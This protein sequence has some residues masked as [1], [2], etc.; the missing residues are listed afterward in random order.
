MPNAATSR[1]GSPGPVEFPALGHADLPL[2]HRWLSAPH[3]RTW[4]RDTLSLEEVER[5][6]GPRIDGTGPIRCFVIEVEGDPIGM[7]QGYRHADLPDGERVGGIGVPAAAGIDYLIGDA[8]RCGRGIGSR[9]I[10][11][12]SAALFR[13]H[14]DVSAIVATPQKDNTASCRALEKAGFALS[15]DAVLDSGDPSDSG[16]SAVYVL[17]RPA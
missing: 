4:W 12:F 5:K 7:I 17:P 13:L 9:V 2:L 6:Y 16:V 1:S 10:S 8:A 14:P 15:H 3:V 11:A